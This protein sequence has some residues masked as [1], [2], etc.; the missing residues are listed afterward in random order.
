VFL[1]PLVFIAYYLPGVTHYLKTDT[2]PA[3]LLYVFSKG[4]GLISIS[5]LIFQALIGLSHIPFAAPLKHL[6]DVPMQWHA[7]IGAILCASLLT[8]CLCFV[9]ATSLR[10]GHFAWQ[11]LLPTFSQGYYKLAISLGA[12]ALY[13]IIFAVCARLSSSHSLRLRRIFHRFALIGT[14]LAT[15]HAWLIGSEI[16]QLLIGYF[17]ITCLL[18]SILF[19]R[20][21]ARAILWKSE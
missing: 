6:F 17:T 18:L 16:R 19:L 15:A 2:P 5:I 4:M 20:K 1:I 3:Q 9:A 14:L 12:I 21:L 8:H 13:F 10:T 11:L 7:R